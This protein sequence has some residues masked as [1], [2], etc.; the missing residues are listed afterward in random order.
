MT[1][2][3]APIMSLSHLLNRSPN[4]VVVMWIFIDRSGSKVFTK[5]F[6]VAYSYDMYGLAGVSHGGRSFYI[7]VHGNEH[8]ELNTKLFCRFDQNGYAWG[9]SLS[10]LIG[11]MYVNGKWAIHPNFDRMGYPCN[12][13]VVA[14][15]KGKGLCFD[16]NGNLKFSL[17][18]FRLSDTEEF[19]AGLLKVEKRQK[20]YFI[21]TFGNLMHGPYCYA[22]EYSSGL[23]YTRRHVDSSPIFVDIHGKPGYIPEPKWFASEYIV[24]DLL[25]VASNGLMG[26]LNLNGDLILPPDYEEIQVYSC[27]RVFAIGKSGS[28]LFDEKGVVLDR[29]PHGM[30][31]QICADGVI[32][33]YELDGKYGY[34]DLIRGVRITGN[35]FKDAGIMNH[36]LAPVM[37]S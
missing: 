25:E 33:K 5:R 8:M 26:L 18:K 1:G 11:L 3:T 36:G 15:R 31:L 29:L 9:D 12:G 24:S 4:S 23:C 19:R 20:V 34:Y 30:R 28:Y 37:V 6:D 13:L 21:D 27:N 16:I 22:S 10:G 7:D 14:E 35:C 2:I 32:A 17:D